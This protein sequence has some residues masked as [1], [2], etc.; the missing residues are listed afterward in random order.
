MFQRLK[1]YV[2]GGN[3]ATIDVVKAAP[4]PSPLAPVD[5]T[6]PVQVSGVMDLAARIGDILLSSGTGNNDAKA[7]IK[8]V[9]SA[10]GLLYTHVDITLNTITIFAHIGVE[11]RPVSVFRVVRRLSIDFSKLSEVDRLIRSIQ[12]GATP[13]DVA[14][15]TLDDLMAAP[16]PFGFRTSLFGWALLAGAVAVLLGGGALVSV[17]SFLSA[18]VI[19]GGSAWLDAR[20]LPPFFQNIFGGFIATVPAAIMYRWAQQSGVELAPGQIIASGIVVMLAGL[21]LVQ[22]IQDGITGAPVTAS[23]RFFETIMMTGG[24]VAGVVLGIETSA[25]LGITLPVYE[26]ATSIG[27]S[28]AGVKV[29]SGALASAGFAIACYS[30][31]GSV[32]VSGMTAAAGSFIYYFALVPLGVGPVVGV[33]IAATVIGLAG[34]L[35]ARRFQIPPLIT[36]VA[37]ITPLLPGLSIYRGMYAMMHDQ[38]LVSYKLLVVA[39]GTASALAAGVVLGEWVARKLRRPPTFNPYRRFRRR[40]KSAFSA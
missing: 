7:H 34:G 20:G 13:P 12:A 24:I 37:G 15:R 11:K 36:A 4:P 6:D 19:M 39:L 35:L 23:A 9:A 25:A 1:N 26:S 27:F 8:A 10:Y 5:L 32:W 16:P 38:L 33:G 22:A 14:E 28:S 31:W 18:I 40:K 21:T 17:I 29:I 3:A 2:T 30:E